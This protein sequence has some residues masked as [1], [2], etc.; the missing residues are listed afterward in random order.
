MSESERS[1]RV[2][3][4]AEGINAMLAF[5]DQQED[6]VLAAKVADVQAVFSERYVAVDG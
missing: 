5:A 3:A 1:D 6:F 2:R 4:I